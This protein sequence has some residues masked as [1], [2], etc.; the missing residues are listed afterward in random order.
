M[1]KGRCR[2]V[3]AQRTVFTDGRLQI[4]LHENPGIGRA[5]PG[6][7]ETTGNSFTNIPKAT[8]P[9]NPGRGR[10]LGENDVPDKGAQSG[11]CKNVGALK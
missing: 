5:A 7:S 11:S 4:G 3:D 1:P 9:Q 8:R 2:V 6:L 10:N